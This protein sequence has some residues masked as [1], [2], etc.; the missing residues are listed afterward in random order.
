[1]GYMGVLLCYTQAIF[2]LL[3][4]AI[5]ICSAAEIFR[6]HASRHDGEMLW[7]DEQEEGVFRVV[8]QRERP[9]SVFSTG[10]AHSLGEPKI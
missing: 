3:N 9:S 8:W 10:T 4:G 1:M 6:D 5:N 2:Y 7:G